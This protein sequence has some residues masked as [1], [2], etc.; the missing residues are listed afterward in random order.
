MKE[1]IYVGI[2]GFAGS[3]GRYL[4]SKWLPP[5][6]AAGTFPL[7]TFAVNLIGSLLIGFLAAILTKQSSNTLQLILITGF[8][9]GFTTFST[10]SAEGLKLLRAGHTIPYFTYLG[11]SI[12]GG[13]FCCM[14][15]WWIAQ[16]IAG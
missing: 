13:L 16:K 7:G 15:G 6:G 8:C 10:F 14:I 2:G 5:L 4:I 9:G 12:T 3:A 1:I 11:L